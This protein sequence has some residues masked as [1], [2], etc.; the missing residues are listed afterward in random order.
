MSEIWLNGFEDGKKI[1]AIKGIRAVSGWSLKD[2]K[3]LAYDVERGVRRA[4]VPHPSMTVIDAQATLSEHGVQFDVQRI[5]L[6]ILVSALAEYPPHIT[7]GDLCAVLTAA[8]A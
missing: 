3:A 4:V 7:V 1:Q 6:D 8:R 5:P 2:S